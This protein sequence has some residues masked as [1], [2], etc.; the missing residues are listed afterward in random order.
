MINQDIAI[1]LAFAG[2]LVLCAVFAIAFRKWFLAGHESEGLVLDILAL[3]IGMITGGMILLFVS[4]CAAL[5]V[6]LV[7]PIFAN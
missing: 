7:Q 1:R 6:W 2:A 3:F 4:I 5:L